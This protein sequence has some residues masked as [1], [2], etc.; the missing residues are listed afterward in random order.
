MQFY[1]D[2]VVLFESLFLLHIRAQYEYQAIQKSACT[3]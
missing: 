3:Y 1:N 2:S